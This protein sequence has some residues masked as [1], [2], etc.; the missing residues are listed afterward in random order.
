MSQRHKKFRGKNGG[1]TPYMVWLLTGYPIGYRVIHHEKYKRMYAL[2]DRD[3]VLKKFVHCSAVNSLVL[4][5]LMALS[6]N[7]QFFALTPKGF[8][9]AHERLKKSNAVLR[10]TNSRFFVTNIANEATQN[11]AGQ[12]VGSELYAG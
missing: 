6:A 9:I 5:G 7:K 8:D 12:E 2:V 11:A 10:R 1:L 4:K 3:G